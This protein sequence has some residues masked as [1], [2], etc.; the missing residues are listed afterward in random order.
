MTK[1]LVLSNFL[2]YLLSWPFS[3]FF[4]YCLLQGH[5][6]QPHPTL[7]RVT[8]IIYASCC[9]SVLFVLYLCTN[10]AVSVYLSCCT[11]VLNALY[12]CTYLAEHVYLSECTCVLIMLYL[13]TYL[14]VHFVLTMLYMWIYHLGW[15]IKLFSCCV[16]P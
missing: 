16:V 5:S 3:T 2:W 4:P 9:T 8:F 6:L 10:L 11:F 15:Y 14:A 7:N 12:M 13:C 1:Y